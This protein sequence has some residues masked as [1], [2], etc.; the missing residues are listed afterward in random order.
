VLLWGGRWRLVALLLTHGVQEVV[1]RVSHVDTCS[2]VAD[3]IDVVLHTKD[4]PVVFVIMHTKSG[5][6]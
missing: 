4:I 3:V 5:Q 2:F 1:G 6:F